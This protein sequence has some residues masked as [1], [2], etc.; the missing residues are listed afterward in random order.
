[1]VIGPAHTGASESD[2]S[3]NDVLVQPR[4]SRAPDAVPARGLQDGRARLDE[5]PKTLL[6][7]M[8]AAVAGTIATSG[9]SCTSTTRSVRHRRSRLRPSADLRGRAVQSPGR[10]ASGVEVLTEKRPYAIMVGFVFTILFNSLRMR[11]FWFPFHPVGFAIS[12]RWSMHQLWMCMLI[13]WSIKLLLLR[14]GGVRPYRNGGVPLPRAHLGE[15]VMG[16]CGRSSASPSTPRRTR[17][18]RSLTSPTRPT[19]PPVRPIPSSKKPCESPALPW[20]KRFEAR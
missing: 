19:A 12:S 6:A 14:F 9:R 3:V 17:F 16:S 1:M 18:G 15:C 7:I 20:N 11:F 4:L 13:A 5:L 8:I 2:H 10:M